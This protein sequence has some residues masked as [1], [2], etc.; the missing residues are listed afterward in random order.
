MLEND[1]L[2]IEDD[3]KLLFIKS[4]ENTTDN[5]FLLK[6]EKEGE[7]YT[8]PLI[9]NTDF[10]E[11]AEQTLLFDSQKSGMPVFIGASYKIYGSIII[12]AQVNSVLF[13]DD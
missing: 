8:F 11:P 4:I 7:D 1:L 5:T 3:I 10:V 9:L 2:K 6:A 12:K 13:F